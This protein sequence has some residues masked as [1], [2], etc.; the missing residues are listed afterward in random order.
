MLVIVGIQLSDPASDTSYRVIPS[1]ER[2]LAEMFVPSIVR[3][4]YRHR[5]SCTVG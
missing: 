2:T 5:H 4:E 3:E 1:P